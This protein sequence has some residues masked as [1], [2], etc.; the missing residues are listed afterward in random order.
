MTVTIEL[1]KEEETS[2][3]SLAD[4]Q[5][6]D[7]PT[8]IRY[9]ILQNGMSVNT[10]GMKQIIEWDREEVLGHWQDRGDAQELARQLRYPTGKS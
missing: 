1:T 5:G 10:W 2:L 8:M 6:T 7:I 4:N 9:L 3:K